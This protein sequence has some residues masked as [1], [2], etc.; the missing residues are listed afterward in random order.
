MVLA[1]FGH[2][3]PRDPPTPTRTPT[4]HAGADPLRRAAAQPDP[5]ARPHQG[6]LDG[7]AGRLLA[8]ALPP[9]L[10]RHGAGVESLKTYYE[11][12]SSGRYSVDGQVTD[13]V[14]VPFNEARYGRSNGFPCAG[15]VCSNSVELIKDGA[16]H[17]GRRPARQGPHRRADQ[18]GPRRRMTSGTA[19]TSTTTA[20]ST[21]PTATSTTSRS[22]TPAAT[23]P[24]ATRSRARTRSG[25]TAG[26]RIQGTGQGP[27]NAEQGRRRADRH[28]RP[29]GRGLHDPARERRRLRVRARVRPRP[30]PARRVR[31]AAAGRTTAS[32]WWTLMAQSRESAPQDQGI[33]TRAADLGAWDKLQLGW[34]DY[35]VGRP[36][37]TQHDRPRPARV[38]LGQGPGRGRRAAEEGGHDP[39]RRAGRRL[40]A[41]VVAGRRRP[42]D[43]SMTREVTLPAGGPRDADVPGAL[44]HR[45]LRS[46]RVR[47][48]LRRGRRRHRLQ[49]DPRLDHQG[50][51]G[52]RHRRRA[53][54]CYAGDVRPLGVRRQDDQAALPLPDRRRGQGT[55]PQTVAGL[56]A[57]EIKVTSGARPCS[58][59]RRDG[60]DGWTLDGFSAVGT[61]KTERATTTTTSRR[62]AVRLLRPATCSPGRTTSGSR[63][64]RTGWS[65]SRTR[66]ACSS[67]TGTR[68]SPTTTEPAP[69][70]GRDPADRLAPGSDLPPR[71]QAV[72]RPDPDLRRAVLAREGRLVHPARPG[73]GRASYIRGQSAVPLFDDR[74][75]FWDPAI[76]T[77]GVKVPHAGVQIRVLSQN[78]T[79]MRIRVQP[80]P[81]A[82]ARK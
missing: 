17:V 40:Q 15:N 37:S 13:W 22:S 51:R 49:A 54:D 78:G 10:L 3:R 80:A 76:P 6:Q 47:L 11:R 77:V 70:P 64:S 58:R 20:T 52:Q 43:D 12:Q 35:E 16:R 41:V 74:R 59:R 1:E 73:T 9:A 32:S 75:E 24:T 42:R 18:G 60:A 8:R 81:A 65:T 7:L 45:G 71:R 25:R 21:S 5:G 38:Q 27:D 46:R 66:T 62:T 14:K 82:A 36:A 44:E 61:T 67:P 63:T 48:R 19:T 69:R 34:L 72:A 39:A 79:S 57:D 56:F 26:R 4:G 23:R 30:R 53:G 31:H 55:D 68:R 33:G 29:V 50:R 2:E 28:H